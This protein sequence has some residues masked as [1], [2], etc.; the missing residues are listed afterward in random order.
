MIT[1]DVRDLICTEQPEWASLVP[2]RLLGRQ[3]EAFVTHV[4]DEQA[5]RRACGLGGI[6]DSALLRVLFDLPVGAAV[7][8]SGLS[9]WACSVLGRSPRGAVKAD[10][11]TVTRL[12]C[13][14]VKVEMVVVRARDWEH[15]IYWASQF[16]PFCRRAL[17]LPSMPAD[18]GD[19][20]L[21][22]AAMFGIGVIIRRQAEEGWLVPPAPFRPQRASSGQ[23]LFHERA[24]AGL[25]HSGLAAGPAVATSGVV[26]PV[27]EGTGEGH[28]PVNV[29]G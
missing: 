12:A 17:V 2:A 20:L 25:W 27:L 1:A 6:E 11:E 16:G 21:L 13:P 7:P 5:R 9:R 23:W 24:Y 15:G 18:D 3:V 4:G 8:W 10:R 19:R 26:Q 14:A 22:E 28:L 29:E